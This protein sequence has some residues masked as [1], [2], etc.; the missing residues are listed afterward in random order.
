MSLGRVDGVFVNDLLATNDSVLISVC[1][2]GGVHSAEF[3]L[4]VWWC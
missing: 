1:R 4:V 3:T 2:G